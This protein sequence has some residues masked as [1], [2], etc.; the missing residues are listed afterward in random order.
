M[1]KYHQHSSFN[2]FAQRVLGFNSL[3]DTE[4]NNLQEDISFSRDCYSDETKSI[5]EL[6]LMSG[7]DCVVSSR[8]E[9]QGWERSERNVAL[10]NLLL[11]QTFERLEQ[12]NALIETLLAPFNEFPAN[13]LNELNTVLRKDYGVHSNYETELSSI[14]ENKALTHKALPQQLEL[15]MLIGKETLLVSSVVSELPTLVN[16]EAFIAVPAN[17]RTLQKMMCF[18]ASLDKTALGEI[19]K[20]LVPGL[21]AEQQSVLICLILSASQNAEEFENSVSDFDFAAELPLYLIVETLNRSPVKINFITRTPL[22][23][24]FFDQLDF[25]ESSHLALAFRALYFL[26]DVG[27]LG[28]LNAPEIITSFLRVNDS[29]FNKIYRDIRRSGKVVVSTDELLDILSGLENASDLSLVKWVY[30]FSLLKP[31][32]S[33]AEKVAFLEKVMLDK[34]IPAVNTQESLTLIASIGLKELTSNVIN[35]AYYADGITPFMPLN[36]EYT[37]KHVF[38]AVLHCQAQPRDISDCPEKVSVVITTFNPDL[39]LLEASIH[40]VFNQT[41]RNIEVI[42]VDDCSTAVTE[43]DIRGICERFDT[44]NI[45]YTRNTENVGQ[46]ISRNKAI[47]IAQGEYIAIQDDD[48]VSHPQRIAM[49]IDRIN[50]EASLASFTKHIRFSDDGTL[51]IDEP[52]ELLTFGDGPASLLFHRSLLDLIGNFRDYRSRGD[53][54]FRTRIET[55]VGDNAISYINSPLYIMRSAMTTIS[56][57]YEYKNGDLLEYFRNRVQALSAQKALS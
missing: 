56:S 2:T 9:I 15:S 1:K 30:L 28:K 46:Y 45:I 47:E 36:D 54:D 34:G 24:Y 8:S 35:D 52:R 32:L 22:L 49:Q 10:N 53:I 57:L 17:I 12:V 4:L 29:S 42:L 20:A 18:K 3:N 39:A 44:Q 7:S 31:V 48:D 6:K 37:L 25:N 23:S 21:S 19:S 55:I 40:S 14:I 5:V 33:D 50:S 38:N 51:S 26:T 43:E 16:D 13:D 27:V 11:Q 41:Y